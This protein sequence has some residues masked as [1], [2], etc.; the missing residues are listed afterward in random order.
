MDLSVCVCVLLNNIEE[1]HYDD[2]DYRMGWRVLY[3]AVSI[4]R[5]YRDGV[6]SACHQI[7]SPREARLRYGMRPGPVF[8]RQRRRIFQ[9]NT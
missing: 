1:P 3:A 2:G 7:I 6:A 8:L 4:V 5:L 9:T